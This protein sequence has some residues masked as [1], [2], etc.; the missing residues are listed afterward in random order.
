MAFPFFRRRGASREPPEP[1][2]TAWVLA[3]RAPE[4]GD[5]VEALLGGRLVEH[6]AARHQPVPAWAV[7]NKVAHA[8]A[9]ELADL[10]DPRGD[11]DLA[12]DER[13]PLWQLAQRAL[14]AKL[15][16]AAPTPDGLAELQQTVLVPLELWMIGRS[17]SET[18]TSRR[19]IEAALDLL[20]DL[21]TGR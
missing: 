12:P 19:V 6:L 7:L 18:I 11:G 1:P 10:A 9:Q 15:V 21:R 5:E 17:R 13:L 20:D 16:D 3:E 4:L 2:Q 8:H 14:A